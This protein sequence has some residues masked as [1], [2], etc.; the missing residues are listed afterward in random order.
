[1]RSQAGRNFLIAVAVATGLGAC[2]GGSRQD[3][4]EPSGSF[5]VQ[6]P[7]ATFPT[8][9]QLAERTRLVID[10]RNTSARTLPNVAV[11]ICNTTCTYPAPLGQGTSVQPFAYYLPMPG[12]VSHSR[13]VWIV[14]RPPGACNYSCQNGGRGTDFTVDAN[15]WAA[16]QLKPGA[17]A[18]FAWDVTAVV[19]GRYTVAWQVSAGIYGKAKAVLA[20]GTIPRGAFTVNIA[21]APAQSFVNDQG[22]IVKSK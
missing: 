12:L 16:G 22:A 11:T 10:V 5:T 21:H 4:H 3:V 17:T 2:G 6:V 1:M 13:P 7:T 18:R 14:D 20:D 15:T 9:Q 8:H 19:P